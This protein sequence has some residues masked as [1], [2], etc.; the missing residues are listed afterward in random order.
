MADAFTFQTA[1]ISDEHPEQTMV[2]E[3]MF[4]SFGQRKSFSGPITT[5]KL[6][7]DNTLVREVLSEPGEGRVLVV[8]G[9]GS[10]RCALVGDRIGELARDNGWAGIL[11]YGSIR[12]SM[13]IEKMDIGVY[14]LGTS[15]QKSIKQGRG[16]K[17]LAVT[18]AGVTF[19]PGHFIYVDGDGVLVS[20]TS[21]L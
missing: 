20:P 8:D 15:P 5:L 13:I 16:D 12:D 1:D 6:F 4:R 9:G 7:E 21:L 17:E 14:A 18:F 19:T 10:K 3:S 2:A 11:V